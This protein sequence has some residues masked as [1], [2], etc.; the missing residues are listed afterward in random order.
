[1]Q[2]LNILMTVIQIAIMMNVVSRLTHIKGFT[3]CTESEL[4]RM[5]DKILNGIVFCGFTILTSLLA[6]LVVYKF[7]SIY[8]LIP[9]FFFTAAIVFIWVVRI[10]E[11]TKFEMLLLKRKVERAGKERAVSR[12]HGESYEK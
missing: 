10:K 3:E 1:M 9:Q 5:T 2:S 11:V 4:N 6:C 12:L 7:N 8:G